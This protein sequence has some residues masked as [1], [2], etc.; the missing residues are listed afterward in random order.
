MLINHPYTDVQCPRIQQVYL[1]LKVY[2]S[3]LSDSFIMG[4]SVIGSAIW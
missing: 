4:V 1:I 2:A 3:F